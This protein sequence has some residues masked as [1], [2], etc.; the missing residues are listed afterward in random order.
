MNNDLESQASITWTNCDNTPNG[1]ILNPG[2]GL[3]ICAC[4]GSVVVGFGGDVTVTDMGACGSPEPTPTP[5]P[6]CASKGWLITTCANTCSGG[7]CTC[8]FGTSLVVYT[9]CSVTDITDFGTELFTNST[10]T[11]SYVGFF[12]RSGS[13]WYSDGATVIEECVIGGPC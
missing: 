13:I 6:T 10:L 5:T 1:T 12:S 4:Q 9:I 3:S 2:T 7:Y 11:T 8:T